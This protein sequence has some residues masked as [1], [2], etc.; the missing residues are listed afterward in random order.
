MR[1]LVAEHG[2]RRGQTGSPGQ[3]EGGA[4][5]QAV[6]KV[7]DAVADGDH[8]GQQ[9]LLCRRGE[10]RSVTTIQAG[11]VSPSETTHLW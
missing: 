11:D 9:A 5:G 4:H 1:Q 6:G 8:I 3:G 2:Q 7:V 10:R